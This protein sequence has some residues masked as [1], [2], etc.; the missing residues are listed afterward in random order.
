[1]SFSPLY[2]NVLLSVLNFVPTL[3]LKKVTSYLYPM[4]LDPPFSKN[5]LSHTSHTVQ[6]DYSS[7]IPSQIFIQLKT[8]NSSPWSADCILSLAPKA[9]Y[10]VFSLNFTV[11]YIMLKVSD[12]TYEFLYHG[13]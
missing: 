3:P 13:S 4:E 1:M 8:F 2:P 7:E 9:H 5:K 12:T 10:P 6:Y 11:L